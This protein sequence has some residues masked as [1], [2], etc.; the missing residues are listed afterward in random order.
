M[1][2]VVHKWHACEKVDMEHYVAEIFNVIISFFGKKNIFYKNIQDC[3]FVFTL[4]FLLSRSAMLGSAS[5]LLQLVFV[6]G[7]KTIGGRLCYFYKV[8]G[9]DHSTTSN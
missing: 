5:H 3:T 1:C 2:W 6:V 9:G 8:S 4:L 7:P